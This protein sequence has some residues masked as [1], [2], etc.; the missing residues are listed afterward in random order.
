MRKWPT[1]LGRN[2]AIDVKNI[3]VAPV[4]MQVG[5]QNA[6][7]VVG[8][9]TFV[10]FQHQRA[11]A[12]AE[13]DAGGAIFPIDDPAEGFGA[14]HDDALGLARDD[15]RIGLGQRKD[16]AR[17]DGLNVEGKPLF[18]AESR[19]HHGGGGREGQVGG[20]RGDDQRVDVMLRSCQ[21]QRARF[22]RRWRPFGCGL[23]FGGEVTT[24]DAGARANPV[25][26]VSIL[27]SNQ[28]W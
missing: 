6:P 22:Q 8:A 25:V 23:A 18:H 26:G 28:R 1:E 12:V 11:C 7:V 9:G 15:Q 17:A 2:A 20:R 21:P 4:G 14:D 5:R 10:G 27:S 24:F 13:Q 3:A 19:L 16:E